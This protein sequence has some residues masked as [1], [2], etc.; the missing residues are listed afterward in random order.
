MQM[1]AVLNPVTKL[2]WFIDN[3]EEEVV[4]R[5]KRELFGAVSLN[6]V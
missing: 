2:Q 4:T 3:C 5:V 1:R 6:I